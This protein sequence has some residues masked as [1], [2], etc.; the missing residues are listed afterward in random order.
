[1]SLKCIFLTTNLK[2]PPMNQTSSA[3]FMSVSWLSVFTLISRQT[4]ITSTDGHLTEAQVACCLIFL[5]AYQR[6]NDQLSDPWRLVSV[7]SSLHPNTSAVSASLPH[8]ST[9]WWW[10]W[11]RDGILKSAL[12]K[13]WISLWFTPD[14][15]SML[16]VWA[17]SFFILNEDAKH[18]FSIFMWDSNT[19]ISVLWG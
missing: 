19:K 1:M 10:C 15:S 13:A 18:S 8:Q 9:W 6:V 2:F 14:L 4:R 16:F 3:S 11:M 17:S 7:T 5:S 12:S